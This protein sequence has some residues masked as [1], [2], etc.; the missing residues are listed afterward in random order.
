MRLTKAIK[1]A[2]LD[3]IGRDIPEVAIKGLLYEIEQEVRNHAVSRLPTD[4]LKV[5]ND[6]KNRTYLRYETAHVQ[7][8]FT[9]EEGRHQSL[10]I[11]PT[12]PTCSGDLA[13]FKFHNLP[14]AMADDITARVQVAKNTNYAKKKALDTVGILLNSCS[15]TKKLYTTLPEELHK[16]IIEE[17]EPKK[18]LPACTSVMKDLR[19]AGWPKK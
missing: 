5:Y 7:I 16:Y 10:T 14:E 6:K 11:Y 8:P 2:I 13:S 12:I 4:V 15:T 18:F 1:Q 19:E 9:D 3:A 17:E